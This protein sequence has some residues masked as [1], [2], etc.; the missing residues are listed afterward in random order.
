VRRDLLVEAYT[1]FEQMRVRPE[2]ADRFAE[3]VA[4]AI[5]AWLRT[6]TR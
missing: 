3:P 5:D 6:R 2:A 1:P 4:T